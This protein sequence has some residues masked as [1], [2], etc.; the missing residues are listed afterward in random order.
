MAANPQSGPIQPMNRQMLFEHALADA[1]QLLPE[2]AT[3]QEVYAKAQEI[4][5]RDLDRFGV[6]DTLK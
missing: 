2:T 3:M 5:E 6:R 4:F 1:R